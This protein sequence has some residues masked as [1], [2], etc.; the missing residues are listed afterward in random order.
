M[1]VSEAQDTTQI[2]HRIYCFPINVAELRGI[3]EGEGGDSATALAGAES[4]A[5][6]P[7]QISYRLAS[8]VFAYQIAENLAT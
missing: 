7:I 3:A 2:R 4:L 8:H 6:T 5:E 1:N